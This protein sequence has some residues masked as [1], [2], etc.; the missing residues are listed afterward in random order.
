M[1]DPVAAAAPAGNTS[2]T[3]A[4]AAASVSAPLAAGTSAPAGAV[5]ATTP[6]ATEAPSATAP[7]E[8]VAYDFKSSQG[9]VDPGVLT[10]FEGLARE[11]NLTQESASKLIDEIAPE[12]AKAQDARVEAAKTGW[13]EAAKIDKEFG[14]EKL[15]ENMAIAKKALDS[16]GS[17]ELTKMLNESGLGNHPEIIRAFYR[18]GLQITSGKFVP[19][20]GAATKA[21]NPASKLYPSMNK[22]A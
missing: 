12:M 2:S 7:A 1:P 10:K 3:A 11:L 4:P 18:A 16:F 9:K 19:A 21:S 6:L 17:P 20:G 13:L 15:E 5:A 14:G 8:P 22:G